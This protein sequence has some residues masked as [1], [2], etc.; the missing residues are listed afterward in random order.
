M[1]ILLQGLVQNITVTLVILGFIKVRYA[2]KKESVVVLLLISFSISICFQ[3]Y[4]T[5]FIDIIIRPINK[6]VYFGLYIFN[7]IYQNIILSFFK[8]Y[9][10]NYF[11]S[12]K[13]KI[14]YSLKMNFVSILIFLIFLLILILFL[15]K[16]QMLKS[17]LQIAVVA[18]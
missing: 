17:V 9:Y 3:L 6:K 4:S 18:E 11:L 15:F 14:K 7:L 16:I 13:N 1:N 5:L 8:F 10:S 2:R 12:R